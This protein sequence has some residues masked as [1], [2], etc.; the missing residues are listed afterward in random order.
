MSVESSRITR[1]GLI[2]LVLQTEKGME[3]RKRLQKMMYF[4]NEL[5]WNAFN[6]Y[7]FH[8]Y[9]TYSESLAQEMQLMVSNG[10]LRETSKGDIYYYNISYDRQN[11]F[12]SLVGKVRGMNESLFKRSVELIK[13]L[14]DYSTDMLEV[15]STLVYLRKAK[16]GLGDEDLIRLAKD[17]KPQ[18]DEDKFKKGLKILPVLKQFT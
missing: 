8:Y 7:K 15:T 17:L 6:D 10:W 18:F 5:G 14:G 12:N 2:S 4:L 13:Q 16:P 11:Y 9:G 1:L 3:G